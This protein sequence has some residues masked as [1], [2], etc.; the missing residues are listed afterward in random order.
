MKRV[1]VL[2]N[3]LIAEGLCTFLQGQ[4]YTVR[5]VCSDEAVDAAVAEFSPSTIVLCGWAIRD[6]P[7]AFAAGLRERYLGT[8]I[9]GICDHLKV[10]GIRTNPGMGLDALLAIPFQADGLAAAISA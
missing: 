3:G 5:T 10:E 4:G 6:D 9:V 2:A 8:R 7:P 1:L